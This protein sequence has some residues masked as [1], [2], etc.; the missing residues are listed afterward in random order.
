MYEKLRHQD[1]I[2]IRPTKY[3]YRM[4]IKNGPKATRPEVNAT[5]FKGARN[6]GRLASHMRADTY[7]KLAALVLK[8][9][10]KLSPVSALDY[11]APSLNC[12]M[13][14]PIGVITDPPGSPGVESS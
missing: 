13:G 8:I 4:H 3:I 2:H 11:M 5:L 14:A 9:K 7:A 6:N 10:V 12:G 1:G